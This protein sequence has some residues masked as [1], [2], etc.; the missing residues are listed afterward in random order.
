MLK[1]AGARIARVAGVLLLLAGCEE[2]EGVDVQPL[3]PLELPSA[4]ARAGLPEV[5][6]VWRFAGWDLPAADTAV[7]PEARVP[8][9]E[10]RVEVQQLDSVAGHYLRGGRAFPFVGEVRRD[11]I[12]SVVVFDAEGAGRF[13]AGRVAGDTLW[14]ELT[15][16]PS[17]AG[18]SEGTRAALVRGRP[19]AP[20][21]R[22][23]PG[24]VLPGA[25][26]A[27]ADTLA[28]QPAAPQPGPA[29]PVRPAPEPERPG[30]AAPA[31]PRQPPPARPRPERPAPQPE[32]PAREPEP[33]P[34]PERPEPRPEPTPERREPPPL[35]GEP[36]RPPPEPPGTGVALRR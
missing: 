12:V 4:E 13:V 29:V 6:G 21:V 31:R 20:F 27:A 9:G 23:P 25:D 11:G 5:E 34:E 19:G 24:V 14:V 10:L 30:T 35:L 1:R 28:P 2:A 26:T 15:S 36:V 3:P 8:P 33:E 16:L 32:P 18:W 22:F 7:P 17:A